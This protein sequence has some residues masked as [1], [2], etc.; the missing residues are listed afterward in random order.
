MNITVERLP[1]C[2]ARLSAAI[3]ADTVTKTRREIVSA[4]A[5]QAKVPGFRP[6]KI[7]TAVIEKRFADSIEGEL[8]DRLARSA[9]SEART[10][11]S[12]TILGIAQ[13]EREQFE[14]DGSYMLAVEVVTEP[15]VEV[16]EYKGITVEVAKMEVTDEMVDNY[17]DNTRKQH[18]LPV[19]VDQAARPGDLAVIDYTASLDG[20][21]LADQVEKEVGPLATGS[22]HWVDLPEEGQEPREFIPGLAAAVLGMSKGG[23]KTFDATFAEEFPVA[24]VAGKTVSYEVT[25]TQVKARELPELNDAFAATLGLESLE[26]LKER[27]RGQFE[28][29]RE[30]MRT[31]II[32]NQILG[33]L[34][35]D[36]SFDVPQHIVF[37]ETQRQVNQMVSRGYEQG[38]S[39]EDITN[40]QEDLIRSA[41][42][43]AKNNVKVMFLLDQIADKEGITVSDDELTRHVAM[44]AYRQGR[45]LKKVAREFR[46]RN[47]FPELRHDIRVN[48]TIQLLRENAVINEV[49][50]PKE[51]E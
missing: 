35:K 19:D 25:V 16:P 17:L 14:A 2:K 8:K 21:P 49:E 31:Q 33:K 6:G 41:E 42:E 30:R 44:I 1:E 23:T 37:N 3:P 10:K 34:T 47:A 12:L 20:Q 46:D 5:T 13:V 39:E 22:D 7:P 26:Q 36:A 29:Q 32:D 45:P 11:E 24:V 51:G 28:Q 38:M 9:Y 48:K 27:V 40:N 15:D 50:A 18:A 43:Q 4:Y